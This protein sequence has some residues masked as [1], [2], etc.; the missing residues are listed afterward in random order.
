MKNASFLYHYLPLRSSKQIHCKHSSIQ[1][2]LKIAS[3]MIY[4]FRQSTLWGGHH[5]WDTTLP[6]K[7]LS[8][9]KEVNLISFGKARHFS[10]VSVSY[11]FFPPGVSFSSRYSRLQCRGSKWDFF[12]KEKER[13]HKNDTTV[14]RCTLRPEPRILFSKLFFYEK[15][16]L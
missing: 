5:I 7:Q 6:R 15:G 1:T 2:L 4:H 14:G 12:G 8:V 16:G 13:G 3:Q 10:N 11:P 9:E